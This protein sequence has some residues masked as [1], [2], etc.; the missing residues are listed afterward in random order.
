M[1][2]QHKATLRR[3]LRSALKHR[4]GAD[5]LL[6]GIKASQDAWNSAMDKLDADTAIALDTDYVATQA[7]T[8]LFEADDVNLPAQ[9]K[10]TLR[11]VLISSLS[12]R[13]LGNEIAD[14]VEELQ[15]AHNALMTKLDAEAGTLNDTDYESTLAVE[16]TDAEAQVAGAQHKASLRKSLRSA[17]SHRRLA[18]QIMDSIIGL[19]T[20][21][22]AALAEIDGG[23]VNGAMAQFK[24]TAIDPDNA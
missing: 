1:A 13:R 8:S 4:R 7:I 17:L 6:D 5:E 3:S 11:K 10:S 9:H 14:S 20:A 2:A 18:D 22:N 15:T 19:Q 21:M 24:V 16:V 12:H 23:T